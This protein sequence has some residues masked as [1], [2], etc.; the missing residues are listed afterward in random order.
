MAGSK[1][2]PAC[3]FKPVDAPVGLHYRD[4]TPPAPRSPRRRTLPITLA[5]LRR[6]TTFVL[7]FGLAK[8][9][10]F[11]GVLLLPRLLDPVAYGAVELAL[12]VGLLGASI[13]GL[14]TVAAAAQ[15][16]LIEGERHTEPLLATVCG[17]SAL[18]GLGQSPG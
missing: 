12:S 16:H 8:G 1:H 7:S 18:V 3:P 14:G 6:A 13:L 2:D 5:H 11:G 9:L 17:W 10:A 15:L 4:A